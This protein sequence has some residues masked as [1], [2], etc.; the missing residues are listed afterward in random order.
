MISVGSPSATL[1][2]HWSCIG[3]TSCVCR[4][5]LFP[6]L[7]FFSKFVQSSEAAWDITMSCMGLA[8]R[9][10]DFLLAFEAMALYTLCVRARGL[11]NKNIKTC[12]RVTI[13]KVQIAIY[14]VKSC[15]YHLLK[16][17]M[18]LSYNSSILRWKNEL[19]KSAFTIKYIWIMMNEVGWAIVN[20]PQEHS[21]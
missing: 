15:L 5:Q 13:K 19:F 20:K 2:Q 14:V 12:P 11:F 1:A 18:Q 17:Q 3:S 4:Q 16:W 9:K 10:W 7:S 6:G 21:R 8:G